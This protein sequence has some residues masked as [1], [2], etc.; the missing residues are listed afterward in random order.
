VALKAQSPQLPHKAAVGGV[1]LG[2]EGAWA[3]RRAY[4]Q[5][6]TL[7]GDISLDG[8]LVQKM[9]P[10]G[11]EMIVG[12][13]EDEAFGPLVMVGFGG[14][15]VEL[16][17]DVAWAP[18][19]FGLVRAEALIRSLHGA[20]RLDGGMRERPADIG[21]LAQLLAVLSLFADYNRGRIAELDL[22]P[23]VLFQEGEGLIVLDALI[24]TRQS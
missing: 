3:V 16:Q 6:S 20:P 24:V 8:V 15:E 9:A 12:I 19:P 2:V 21:A 13:A 1:V 7:P 18:A 4:E 11:I 5:V 14:M 22:N 10:K 23:V 17:K